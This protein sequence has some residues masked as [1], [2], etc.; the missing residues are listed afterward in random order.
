MKSCFTQYNA[1]LVKY[2]KVAQKQNSFCQEELVFCQVQINLIIFEGHI[3][4]VTVHD[5]IEILYTS[6]ENYTYF[7][8]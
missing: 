5:N 1:P 6:H 3:V 4:S 8:F 2:A 7:F